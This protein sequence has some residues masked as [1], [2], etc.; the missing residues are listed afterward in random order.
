[1]F[2]SLVITTGWCRLPHFV[3]PYTDANLRR[4]VARCF[5]EGT[6][7]LIGL[8]LVCHGAITRPGFDRIEKH[9]AQPSRAHC[10]TPSATS[11]AL[12]ASSV[13][14]SPP[15]APEVSARCPPAAARS[16]CPSGPGRTYAHVP[17]TAPATPPPSPLWHRPCTGFGTCPFITDI[18]LGERRAGTCQDPAR[19][20][21]FPFTSCCERCVPRVC[22]VYCPEDRC[23]HR[24]GTAGRPEPAVG[25]PR[26]FLLATH[27]RGCRRNGSPRTETVE[28]P[29]RS[30][31]SRCSMRGTC[32]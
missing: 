32:L 21:H 5:R 14:S 10:L 3:T 27:L 24:G 8:V 9:T 11:K 26:H 25:G 30:L 17:L 22:R 31:F 23:T 4:S 18:R 29:S 1:M 20:T 6:Q 2:F 15:S 13:P 28:W 16:P 19:D 12:I 7:G